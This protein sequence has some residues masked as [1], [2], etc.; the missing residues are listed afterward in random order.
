VCQALLPTLRA[1]LGEGRH[2]YRTAKA[3][4]TAGL[5]RKDG[6]RL[7]WAGQILWRCVARAEPRAFIAL[8]K[9]CTPRSRTRARLPSPREHLP[10]EPERAFLVWQLPRRRGRREVGRQ[11]GVAARARRDAR[12]GPLGPN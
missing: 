7:R 6:T 10:S 4:Y 11:G 9:L 2:L 5:A 8:A 3:C 12:L 1:T